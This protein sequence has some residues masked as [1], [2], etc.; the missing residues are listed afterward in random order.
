MLIEAKKV[1]RASKV[2]ISASHSATTFGG[3]S[4]SDH[5]DGAKRTLGIDCANA[6]TAL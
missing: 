2:E 3:L 6:H 5:L 4:R 1:P